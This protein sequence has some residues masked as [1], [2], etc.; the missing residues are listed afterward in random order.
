MAHSFEKTAALDKCKGHGDGSLYQLMLC[1]VYPVFFSLLF[2][3]FMVSCSSAPVENDVSKAEVH[4]KLGQSHAAKGDFNDAYIEFQKSIQINPLHKETLN[5]LGHI[6]A[7]FKKYDEAVAFYERA[8]AVDEEYSDAMNNLGVLYLETENWDEA[9]KYFTMALDNPLYRTP[10]R[11]YS[12]LAVAFLKKGDFEAAE[13]AV[14]AALTRVPDDPLATYVRGLLFTEMHEDDAAINSF[15]KAIRNL[16][17][18]IDAHW[19]IAKAYVRIGERDKAVE[20]FRVVADKGND[21]I[22][23][24]AREYLRLLV[25]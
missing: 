5:Y 4:Y 13:D 8:I 25:R 17:G 7:R 22:S 6:S 11:A 16:P 18:Y 3:F 14:N 21:E 1:S 9:I 19:E 24:E 2:I 15:Q 12:N 20:H 10:E 23:R